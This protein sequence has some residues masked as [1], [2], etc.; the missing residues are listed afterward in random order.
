MAET[1]DQIIKPP[2]LLTAQMFIFMTLIVLCIR[3][4]ISAFPSYFYEGFYGMSIP[5]TVYAGAID[6]LAYTYALIGIYKTLERKPFGIIVLKFSLIY[7]LMQLIF[8][9]FSY[10]STYPTWWLAAMCGCV[11]LGGFIFLVY[12]FRSKKLNDYILKSE[13]LFGKYG[14]LGILIY[15][16]VLVQ[17]GFYYGDNI[18][19]YINS[20]KVTKEDIKLGEYYTDGYIKF[21]PLVDWKNDTIYHFNSWYLFEFSSPLHNKITICTGH[22]ECQK[23]LDYYAA[24]QNPSIQSLLPKFPVEEIN[25]GTKDLGKQTLYFNTYTYTASCT[26]NYW[27]YALFVDDESYKVV[28]VIMNDTIWRKQVIINNLLQFSRSLTYRLE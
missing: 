2:F 21:K 4:T 20:Q 19:K 15:L 27:T 17:Y 22:I 24:L 25:Y 16:A 12:L 3:K 23:R 13:R 6:V 8:W 14:W 11:I 28:Y 9:S 26:K 5:L 7:V 18:V 1:K 10:V